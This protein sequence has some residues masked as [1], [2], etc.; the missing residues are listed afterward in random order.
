MRKVL[1]LLA[2]LLSV[3]RVLAQSDSNILY[4]DSFDDNKGSWWIE[5]ASDQSYSSQIENGK[6]A[7]KMRNAQTTRIISGAGEINWGNALK[8]TNDYELTVDFQAQSE[9]PNHA[10]IVVALDVQNNYDAFKFWL[11]GDADW[12]FGDSVS[13]A[14]END[15]GENAAGIALF[16][17][18]PHTLT[19]RVTKAGFSIQI[20]GQDYGKAD[21]R[22]VIGGT[23]G[24]GLSTSSDA[25]VTFDNLVITSLASSSTDA[26]Y[27]AAGNVD[28]LAADTANPIFADDFSSTKQGWILNKDGIYGGTTQIADGVLRANVIGGDFYQ[29]VNTSGPKGYLKKP[30]QME[31]DFRLAKTDKPDGVHHLE[32]DFNK[33]RMKTQNGGAN[34]FVGILLTDQGYWTW[35]GAGDVGIT[36]PGNIPYFQT[37]NI[38]DGEWH[39]LAFNI[40]VS[41]V[42]MAVNIY[43]DDQLIGTDVWD[44]SLISGYAEFEKLFQEIDGGW[45]IDVGT[46]P[47]NDTGIGPTATFEIDNVGLY[48]LAAPQIVEGTGLGAATEKL[49]TG[50]SRLKLLVPQGWVLAP[51]ADPSDEQKNNE[52]AYNL[53]IFNTAAGVSAGNANQLGISI[54]DPVQIM[55]NTRILDSR[56]MSLDTVLGTYLSPADPAKISAEETTLPDGREALLYKSSD[57][58]SWYAFRSNDESVVL[59]NV[60]IGKADDHDKLFPTVLNILQTVDYPTPARVLSG[61]TQAV[62]NL[63]NAVY[64][65][66][67]TLINLS[68]CPADAATMM[69]FLGT[70]DAMT[71]ALAGDAKTPNLPAQPTPTTTKFTLDSSGLYYDIISTKDDVAFVRL[72]GNAHL[73]FEDGTEIISPMKSAVG[74]ILSRYGDNAYRVQRVSGDDWQVCGGMVGF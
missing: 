41:G 42:G 60:E 56:I 44:Y 21:L 28:V 57:T 19:M 13:G 50:I 54:V 59:A 26:G 8:L 27:T 4:Q 9:N 10:N 38:W 1:L 71:D 6:L 24:F 62:A 14:F 7:I 12:N 16:D 33:K 70:F 46:M 32:L 22:G 25:Q 58:K 43:A 61:Q 3:T 20:D 51:K 18:Q 34:E 29:Y 31:F 63:V 48:P 30:F 53:T 55:E 49:D 23:I 36:A 17:D 74:P 5:T 72:M 47:K 39:H 37:T 64:S 66:D 65:D 11:L 52:Q 2:F 15:Y 35:A 73:I 67:E 68:I 45:N 40:Q 69:L